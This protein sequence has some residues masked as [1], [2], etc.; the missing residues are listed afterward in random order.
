MSHSGTPLFDILAIDKTRLDD[1]NLV[2]QL[3][4]QAKSWREMTETEME[5]VLPFI[6]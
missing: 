3:Q 1:S 6:S 4:S 5:G 2:A